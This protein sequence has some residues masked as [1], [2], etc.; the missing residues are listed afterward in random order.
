MNASSTMSGEEVSKKRKTT[1]GNPKAKKEARPPWPNDAKKRDVMMRAFSV[2]GRTTYWRLECG[3]PKGCK[4]VL[5]LPPFTTSHAA[6][7]YAKT[8]HIPWHQKT[9]DHQEQP[10]PPE[11]LS[12]RLQDYTMKELRPMAEG[13]GIR[14]GKMRKHELIAAMES[15]MNGAANG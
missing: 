9:H 11:G 4:K 2:G 3:G 1:K 13:L 14:P 8:V 7:V 15:S 10:Q 6:E 5:D 12:D